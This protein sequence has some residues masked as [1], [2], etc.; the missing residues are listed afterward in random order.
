MLK[1][2]YTNAADPPRPILSSN[3]GEVKQDDKPPNLPANINSN[4][5]HSGPQ[6]STTKSMS[7]FNEKIMSTAKVMNLKFVNVRKDNETK[8]PHAGAL[9]ENDKPG[10]VHDEKFLHKNPPPLPAAASAE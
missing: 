6:H 10:Y 4:V 9:D 7:A 3:L 1:F 2:Y 5:T 8:H